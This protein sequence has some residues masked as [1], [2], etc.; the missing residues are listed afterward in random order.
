MPEL[1]KSVID[2]GSVLPG[3]RHHIP[4]GS[5]G[6]K[7]FVFLSCRHRHSKP[8]IK[9]CQHLESDHCPADLAVLTG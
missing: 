5:K 9:R 1:F 8:F 2:Y 4:Y 7:L 6:R 3:K